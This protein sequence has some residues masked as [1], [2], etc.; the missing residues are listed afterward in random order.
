MFHSSVRLPNG[1]FIKN[2]H[3]SRLFLDYIW[4][5]PDMGVPQIIY[6]NWIFHK[7]KQQFLG[8]PHDYIGNPQVGNCIPF[9]LKDC[10]WNHH[11][12]APAWLLLRGSLCGA[13][14]AS[15]SSSSSSLSWLRQKIW[16][17]NRWI[18]TNFHQHLW[19]SSWLYHHHLCEWVRT[20]NVSFIVQG[21]VW[22]GPWKWKLPF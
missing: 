17:P 1:V 2:K 14:T 3:V 21:V 16:E 4:R 15:A 12:D 13:G 19:L 8:V 5:F 6:L 22:E 20:Q 18:A 11:F 9:I 10:L 7:T